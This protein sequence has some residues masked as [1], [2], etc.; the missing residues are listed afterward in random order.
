[1]ERSA[2]RELRFTL[3]DR[4]TVGRYQQKE[5]EY[6]THLNARLKM[7]NVSKAEQELQANR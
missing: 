3:K 1:M 2:Y 4:R 5:S 6:D 7:L